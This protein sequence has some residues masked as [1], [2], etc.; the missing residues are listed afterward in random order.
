MIITYFGKQFWKVQ[1]GDTTI[2]IN[3]ISKDA[4]GIKTTRFGSDIA[5]VT[6]QHPSYNG[7][8]QLSHGEVEPFVIEGPGE[9][10]VGGIFVKGIFSEGIVDGKAFVNT[11]YT[12][13]ID[14]INICFL[15]N[16]AGGEMNA[17]VRGGIS[18]ADVLFVPVSSS[19]GSLGASEAYKVAVSL[20]PS[21]IIP[22]DYDEKSIK[23]F[24]KEGGVSKVKK[25]D[26]LTIKRK[27]LEG[28]EGEI[29]VFEE[30]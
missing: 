12:F 3:P 11:V 18:E 17:S 5:L 29:V 24:L 21:I 1:Y 14:G 13:M 30:Q 19:E 28:K 8:E 25:V 7:I 2:A 26:K 20:E 6:T 27:D 10:E 15:G 9:Y 23:E 16:I 22:M 4:K